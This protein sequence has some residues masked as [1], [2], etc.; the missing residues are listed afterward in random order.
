MKP[1]WIVLISFLITAGI[2]GGGTYY[3]L[4][5]KA[6]TEKNSLQAQINDLNTKVADTE[7]SLADAQVA[8]PSTTQ[9]VTEATA[10]WKIYTNSTYKFSF[11]YPSDW[12]ISEVNENY[13]DA[14]VYLISLNFVNGSAT[15]TNYIV[16][17]F[18]DGSPTATQFVNNYYGGLEGGPSYI[19]NSTTNGLPTIKFFM[20]KAHIGG[21]AG[22]AYIL[23]KNDST[24]TVV[25]VS[26]SGRTAS[27]GSAAN[28]YNTIKNDQNLNQIASTFQF[29][30]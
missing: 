14:R 25:S 24:S 4:N 10:T 19:T 11:K 28:F 2:V 22:S 17:V 20:E 27:S 9:T 29:T 12:K 3:Y 13:G 21:P 8:T 7:K 1:I 16:E 18:R 23:F 26:T 15:Q 5:K 6:T 30:K